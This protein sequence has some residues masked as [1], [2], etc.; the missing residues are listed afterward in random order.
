VAASR[1]LK[2]LVALAIGFTPLTR[3]DLD[4]ARGRAGKVEANTPFANDALEAL[5]GSSAG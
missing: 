2:Q 1:L 3:L 5:H 4:L